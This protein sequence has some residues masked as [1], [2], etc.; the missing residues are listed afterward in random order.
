HAA[1]EVCDA[2]VRVLRGKAPRATVLIG[3]AG[4]GKTAAI[5]EVVHRLRSDPDGPWRVVR[6]SPADLLA[7]TRFLGEWQTK[8][9]ELIDAVSAPK[10][11]L[12]YVPNL[13]ELSEAGKSSH[14]DSNVASMLAPHIQNGSVAIVGEAT[15]E[16]FRAG[17]GAVASLRRLFAPIELRETT[18]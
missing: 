11:V 14:S 17:L 16:S 8:G 2:I 12:L 10:R 5:H 15:P 13:H 1:D 3:P 4:S 7:G 9:Q 6:V 18:E